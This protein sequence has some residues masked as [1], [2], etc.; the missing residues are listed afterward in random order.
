MIVFNEFL[1]ISYP[2]KKPVNHFLNPFIRFI[3]PFV[4]YF[5]D[6]VLMHATYR[7]SIASL[8]YNFDY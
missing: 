8:M 3:R 5:G 6:F 4:E 2:A 7:C 1:N